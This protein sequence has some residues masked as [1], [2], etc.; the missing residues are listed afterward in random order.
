M[1]RTPG[2]TASQRATQAAKLCHACNT[3]AAMKAGVTLLERTRVSESRVVGENKKSAQTSD[4]VIVYDY[5]SVETIPLLIV[6]CTVT[7]MK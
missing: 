3:T 1:F 4:T 7:Y 5:S 2:P 6:R